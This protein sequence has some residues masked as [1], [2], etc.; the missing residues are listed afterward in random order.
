MENKSTKDLIEA[1]EKSLPGIP[2]IETLR[3]GDH[4]EGTFMHPDLI[5]DLARWLS[6]EFRLKTNQILR[7]FYSGDLF[8]IPEIAQNYNATHEETKISKVEI[9]ISEEKKL[10]LRER[11]I[12]LEERKTK[13][14]QEQARLDKE[15]LEQNLALLDLS[16]PREKLV[17][18]SLKINAIN[19]FQRTRYPALTLGEEQKS[20]RELP[21][22]SILITDLVQVVSKGSK[23]NGKY[24]IEMFTMSVSK[25]IARRYRELHSREPVKKLYMNANGIMVNCNMYTSED[26]GMVREMIRVS[27]D[28]YNRENKFGIVLR[29]K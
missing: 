7:R 9:T 10:E 25:L 19:Y 17:A 28:K 24:V 1:F 2:G 11:E 13:L 3:G 23:T 27:V 18:Q 8:L 12:A 4:T 14:L 21:A 20:P 5:L 29:N 15:I 16:D 6:I 26:E 22:L